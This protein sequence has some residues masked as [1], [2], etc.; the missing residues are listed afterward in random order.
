[1]CIS[2]IADKNCNSEI[3]SQHTS[4]IPK[5]FGAQNSTEC[6]I[7]RQSLVATCRTMAV[8][9]GK[10]WILVCLLVKLELKLNMGLRYIHFVLAV[11]RSTLVQFWD[12]WRKK[13]TVF[14]AVVS[15]C[16]CPVYTSYP[17]LSVPLPS[18]STLPV[19]YQA[20]IR[21]LF[22]T[23]LPSSSPPQL[24]HFPD[25]SVLRP[26]HVHQTA[27]SRTSY[28]NLS[29]T[30]SCDDSRRLP[31]VFYTNITILRRLNVKNCM[32]TL[33]SVLIYNQTLNYILLLF[34]ECRLYTVFEVEY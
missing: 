18:S 5:S 4:R 32:L 6:S 12:F 33:Q 19:S 9:N 27:N 2:A 15:F 3:S 34:S 17:Q 29:P 24:L 22:S 28:Y 10:V 16:S 7:C 13:P 14:P 23:V 31:S 30:S 8:G 20:V 1:M 26:V 21:H 11:Y 25:S